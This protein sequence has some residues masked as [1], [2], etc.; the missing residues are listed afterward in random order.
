MDYSFLKNNSSYSDPSQADL[1]GSLGDGLGG[2]A[3]EG[4]SMSLPWAKFA[5][6]GTSA[7]AGGIMAYLNAKE[8]Q[9][10][11]DLQEKLLKEQNDRAWQTLRDNE[12]AYK[13]SA[14]QRGANVLA[15]TGQVVSQGQ[16]LRDKLMMLR[17]AV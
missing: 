11:R 17:G 12:Q 4:A 14:V 10:Q 5:L 6:Q 1:G 9:K 15:T 3:V 7:A 16:S 8:E 2:A 13:D